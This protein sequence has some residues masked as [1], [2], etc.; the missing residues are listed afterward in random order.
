MFVN[1]RKE[2]KKKKIFA[3]TRTKSPFSEKSAK[4]FLL[5]ANMSAVGHVKTTA[6]QVTAPAPKL[7]PN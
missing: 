6:L 7:S 3:S 5:D 4:A 1:L 2:K